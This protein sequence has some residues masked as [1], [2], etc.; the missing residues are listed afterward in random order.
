MKGLTDAEIRCEAEPDQVWRHSP[1][2]N[3]IHLHPNVGEISSDTSQE[4]DIGCSFNG[5]L[6]LEEERHPDKVETE[7]DGIQSCS[8]LVVKRHD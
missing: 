7:L 1:C 5:T 6:E 4:D 2:C 8:L 3:F